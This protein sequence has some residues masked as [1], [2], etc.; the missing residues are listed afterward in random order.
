M[1]VFYQGLKMSEKIRAIEEEIRK[2]EIRIESL[3][4]E[5]RDSKEDQEIQEATLPL[6]RQVVADLRKQQKKLEKTRNVR[7]KS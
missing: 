1:A 5:K 6:L 7:R 2:M 3:K 4:K